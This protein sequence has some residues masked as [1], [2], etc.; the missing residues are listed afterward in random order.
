MLSP[1][2]SERLIGSAITL[3]GL[4]YALQAYGTL[5]LGTFRRIGPGM[6]P[7]GLGMALTALGVGIAILAPDAN[8]ENPDFS[9]RPLIT[10][11]LGIG[12]FA[13]AIAYL[14]LFPAVV[15]CVLIA[16]FAER[17][18]R[19]VGPISVAVVLCIVAWL[20][21]RIGLGLSIPL[22]KWPF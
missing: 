17:P 11:L 12:A 2:K 10:V 13:V 9:M 4:Y 8:R 1:L 3:F 19:P 7:V 6:F 18:F 20:I 14:G 16:S 15:S 22:L 5:D 21:F